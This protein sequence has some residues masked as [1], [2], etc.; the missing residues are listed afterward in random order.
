MHD[1]LESFEPMNLPIYDWEREDSFCGQVAPEKSLEAC[2]FIEETTSRSL[3][4]SSTD[5]VEKEQELTIPET[6]IDQGYS[7]KAAILDAQEQSTA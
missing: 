7:F 2:L 1:L 6:T 3:E 4:K 5:T